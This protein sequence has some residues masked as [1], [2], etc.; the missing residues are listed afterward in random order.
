[1]WI[2]SGSCCLFNAMPWTSQNCLCIDQPNDID[3][4]KIVFPPFDQLNAMNISE[5]SL[6]EH[7]KIVF[8][9]INWMPQ[10]SQICQEHLKNCLPHQAANTKDDVLSSEDETRA[11]NSQKKGRHKGVVYFTMW[12]PLKPH[13]P[14]MTNLSSLKRKSLPDDMRNTKEPPR[15][16]SEALTGNGRRLATLSTWWHSHHWEWRQLGNAMISLTMRRKQ[17]MLKSHSPFQSLPS[18]QW[19]RDYV[20]AVLK[21]VVRLQVS[22]IWSLMQKKCHWQWQMNRKRL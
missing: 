11:G 17:W 7:L 1:M 12:V 14:I 10:T 13:P 4:S 16:K 8:T 9:L 19:R 3:F 2:W 20:E 6:H 22:L 5:L 18:T 21:A 15:K